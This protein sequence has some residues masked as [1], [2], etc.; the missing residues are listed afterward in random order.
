MSGEG[1]MDFGVDEMVEIGVMIA[2]KGFAEG[3]R[4]QDTRGEIRIALHV[5]IAAG[6]ER[7]GVNRCKTVRGRL[8][9]Q[10]S[11][12]GRKKGGWCCGRTR[13][14][15]A[16]ERAIQHL[17]KILGEVREFGNVANKLQKVGVQEHDFYSMLVQ[18][19]EALLTVETVIVGDA[20]HQI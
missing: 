12:L 10:T 19:A 2:G 9:E 18:V 11:S 14:M 8:I 1:G 5:E 6:G 3:K 15:R 20:G 16:E 4:N 17:G 7:V 13:N